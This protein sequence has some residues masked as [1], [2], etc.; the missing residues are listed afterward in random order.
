MVFARPRPPQ[1]TV[2]ELRP[3]LADAV[4]MVRRDPSAPG[5]DVSVDGEDVAITADG[6]LV[7]ATALNLLLNAAQAMAG[8][9]RIIVTME[10]RNDAAVIHIR[11]TGPGIPLEIRE[12][13]FEPFFTTKARGGG[14]GLPI[15]RRTAELHG[16]TLNL[17]C[18][19]EGGTVVTMTLPIRPAA[20][21][22]AP[23]APQAHRRPESART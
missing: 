3:V 19:P 22:K 11:D 7:R 12:Q 10:R 13:I 5:V 18:P 21:S 1:L 14:L 6:E 16:G 9:G 2:V 20:E 17:S 4:T 23:A 8:H 15:A